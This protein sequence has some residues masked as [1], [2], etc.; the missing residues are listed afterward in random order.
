MLHGDIDLGEIKKKKKTAISITIDTENLE[1]MKK[2]MKEQGVKDIS[3][4]AVFNVLLKHF[5]EKIK[6][7]REQE[8]SK[9]RER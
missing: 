1:Y 6:K 3:L 8:E 9:K 5:V 4:S 7:Q 2:N